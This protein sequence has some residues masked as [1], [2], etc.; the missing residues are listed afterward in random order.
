ME[1]LV[2]RGICVRCLLIKTPNTHTEVLRMVGMATIL[3]KN[4]V[5]LLKQTS[6][7]LE[8]I[9]ETLEV[10]GDSHACKA[11]KEGLRDVKAGRV[12]PYRQF[13]KEL[14]SSHEL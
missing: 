3:R 4:E 9:L 10:A 11:V 6:V 1:G 14:R 7:L 5:E 8:E 13:V 12:R 2:S